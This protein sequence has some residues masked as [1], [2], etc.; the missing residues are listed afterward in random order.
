[1][2]YISSITLSDYIGKEA[3]LDKNKFIK[4]L[5]KLYNCILRSSEKSSHLNRVFP[6]NDDL[7]WG[8]ILKKAFIDMVPMN[9]FYDNDELVFLIRNLCERIFQQNILCLER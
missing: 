2:P 1:M 4:V 9:C 6:Q 5:D 3:G 8:I 7:D